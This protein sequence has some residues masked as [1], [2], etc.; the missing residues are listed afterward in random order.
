MLML[1]HGVCMVMGM[2]TRKIKKEKAYTEIVCDACDHVI[3]YGDVI[4]TTID[5][6]YCSKLCAWMNAA[7]E[8]DEEVGK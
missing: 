3:N 5:A 7:S 6:Q 1:W 8:R 2:S 4:Y